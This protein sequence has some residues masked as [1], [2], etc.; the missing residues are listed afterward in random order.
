MGCAVNG[1]GEAR[2]ADV[3]VACGK[4]KGLIFK[5]GEILRQ[6]PEARIVEELIEEVKGVLAEKV[7]E[8]QRC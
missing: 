2:G 1:P 4:G 5:R 6:V 8:S 3:G 7:V